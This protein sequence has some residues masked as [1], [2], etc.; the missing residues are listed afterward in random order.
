M[1]LIRTNLVGHII[2]LRELVVKALNVTR[3]GTYN[4]GPAGSDIV[5]TRGAAGVK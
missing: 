2:I 5:Y 1:S 4:I 3:I